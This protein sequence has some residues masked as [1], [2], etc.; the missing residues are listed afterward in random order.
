MIVI[1]KNFV[2]LLKN[3]NEKIWSKPFI[4][5]KLSKNMRAVIQT[6]SGP[7]EVLEVREID[8]PIPKNNEILIQIHA[9]SVTV[10]DVFFRKLPIAAFLVF[11]LFGFKRKKIPGHELAGVVV[12]VGKNVTK[13]KKGDQVF[14]TTTGLKYGGN[15]EYICVPEKWKQGLIE[16]K[17]ANISF[18]EVAGVPIG[19]MSAL[20]I[21]KQG[22]IQSG[23]KVLIYGAS[24]SVGTYAVQLAKSF[25]AEVTGV[26]STSNL[27][28][29]KSLGADKVVDYTKEDFTKINETYDVIFD[30]VRKISSSQVK[31]ILNQDGIFLS[32]KSPT[33]ETTKNLIYLR[34]LIEQGKLKSAIDRVY[35]LE[36]IVDAHRYVELGH[37]K[38]NV[39]ISV[40]PSNES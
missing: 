9:G 27:E 12:A 15:A 20:Y 16:S 4:F 2:F 37:K 22:N 8:K 28:M 30:A 21:L 24:G 39:I 32:I 31:S 1:L 25:G 34:N 17:P 36:E 14:G 6:K 13:F 23:Q 10:G 35:P 11:Q 3:R 19:G 33:K 7:P 5:H 40:I 18:E 38:G 26:C 29:V